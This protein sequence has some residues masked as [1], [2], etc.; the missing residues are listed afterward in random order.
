M[1]GKAL[2]HCHRWLH[3]SIVVHYSSFF[4]RSP[5]AQHWNRPFNPHVCDDHYIPLCTN[6]IYFLFIPSGFPSFYNGVWASYC[7]IL[8]CLVL[9]RDFSFLFTTIT[10]TFASGFTFVPFRF[11]VLFSRQLQLTV[12]GIP[13]SQPL[14]SCLGSVGQHKQ[15][16]AEWVSAAAA[17]C[18]ATKPT[19]HQLDNSLVR[20]RDHITDLLSTS[21]E[22]LGL[23]NWPLLDFIL[24]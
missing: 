11:T 12:S 5:V 14:F 9:S 8:T 22:T 13:Q 19:H 2:H 3:L 6:S 16:V 20:E 1:F 24:H 4:D 23:F 7:M 17:N 18:Q 21:F 10:S 15:G